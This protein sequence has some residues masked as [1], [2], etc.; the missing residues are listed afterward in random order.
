MSERQTSALE[1]TGERLIP[2]AF[3]GELVLAEHLARY[4]LACRL[5]PGRRVLDAACG[6][7][8]GSA[9]LAGAGARSVIGI[10]LD[11]PTVLH[12]RERYGVDA[13]LGDIEHLHLAADAVDLLVSFE[14]IEHVHEPER[15]LDEFA[16]VL[17]P[18]GVL[19]I[20]TPNAAEYVEDNPYHLREFASEEFFGELGSRFASVRPLF[21]Q[22]FLGSAILDE[23]DLALADINSRLELEGLKTSGVERGREL[24]ALALCGQRD[25]PELAANVIGLSGIYEAHDLAGLVRAWQARAATAEHHQAEWETRATEAE[26]QRDAWEQRADQA[27][28]NQRAWRER[29]SE[30]E[31]QAAE[32]RAALEDVTASVSW[33]VTRPLRS[34]KSKLQ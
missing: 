18:D 34:A 5:A 2:D 19:L 30:A 3:A 28:Q 26:R 4:A 14:T 23:R 25:L 32:L 15:A 13:R 31:R 22:N 27:E 29:A 11:E 20:S 9:M 1:A 10:D 6:E 7:G 33:R 24:Y 21:Q 12:A 17:S 8:Y 16:R